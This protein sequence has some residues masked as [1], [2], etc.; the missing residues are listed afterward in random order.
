M[1]ANLH[2]EH[3]RRSV[4]EFERAGFQVIPAPVGFQAAE[5]GLRHYSWLP[6]VSGGT[7]TWYACHELL[8]LLWYRLSGRD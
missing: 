4:M 1:P 2:A 3:M 5:G 8:G 7:K 6:A